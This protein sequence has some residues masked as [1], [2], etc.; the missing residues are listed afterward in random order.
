MHLFD[1]ALP[2][3]NEDVLKHEDATVDDY[4]RLQRRLHLERNVLV[5]PS[6]YGRDHR[7]LLAGLRA[8][9]RNAR[10][11]AVIDPSANQAELEEL[12]EAGV[13]GARFNLVQAGATNEGMLEEVGEMIRPFGWHLQ[14]H[15]HPIDLLRLA[16][17]LVALPVP[18]VIDH[19]ARMSAEPAATGAIVSLMPRLLATGKVWLKLSAP[20][21]ASPASRAYEDLDA[22]VRRLAD[23]RPDRLLWGTDWPHVTE[24]KKPDDAVLIN[25]LTRWFAEKQL[26]AVLVENPAHLYKF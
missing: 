19:F 6:G 14:V 21:V 12:Q 3:A 5:Q 24:A 18:V 11:V 20:Y 23:A 25:L 2:F 9:G 13:V 22:F 16:D 26:N 10:G 8:L 4:R 1:T 7:V 17:R 15:A